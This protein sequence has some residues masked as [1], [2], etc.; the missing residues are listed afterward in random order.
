MQGAP[1]REVNAEDMLADLKRALE[2]STRAPDAPPPSA[3][4]AP[5]PR[6]PG[7]TTGL[8]Q[9]DRE[10]DRPVQAKANSPFGAG[11]VLG[12]DCAH[13]FNYLRRL[14]KFLARNTLVI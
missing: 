11:I 1:R 9:I 8:S 5:K 14:F 3:S 2:S 13:I 6:S 12:L 10:R 7:R 4:T